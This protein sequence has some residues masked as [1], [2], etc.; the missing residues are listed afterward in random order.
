MDV[1]LI[2]NLIGQIKI[3][4]RG[5]EIAQPPNFKDLLVA[6][7]LLR[8]RFCG[9]GRRCVHAPE[10]GRLGE[11]PLLS[12]INSRGRR[13]ARRRAAGGERTLAAGARQEERVETRPGAGCRRSSTSE[14]RSSCGAELTADSERRTPSP[15]LRSHVPSFS[16]RPRAQGKEGRG[17]QPSSERGPAGIPGAVRRPQAITFSLPRPLRVSSASWSSGRAARKESDRDPPPSRLLLR[18]TLNPCLLPSLTFLTPGQLPEPR[19]SGSEGG[20]GSSTLPRC[21]AQTPAPAPSLNPRPPRQCAMISQLKYHSSF[22]S[23][24]ILTW[25]RR[26][27]WGCSTLGQ[28]RCSV[29]CISTKL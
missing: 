9:R 12:R 4:K 29:F 18:G 8:A 10:G 3:F 7:F 22:P 27:G 6:A 11:G 15:A 2:F 5:F 14:T 24:T 19:T 26:R 28:G 21:G 1:V 20:R 16:L 23:V 17:V 25:G 13:G